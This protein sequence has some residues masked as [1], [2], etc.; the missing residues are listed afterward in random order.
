MFVS[1]AAP[2]APRDCTTSRLAPILDSVLAGYQT[3][4]TGAALRADAEL[5]ERYGVPRE[6]D[7]AAGAA[8][9][10]LFL[11]SAIYGYIRTAECSRLRR[12]YV[13]PADQIFWNDRTAPTTSIASDWTVRQ[14]RRRLDLMGTSLTP[15]LVVRG[16]DAAL[17][18]YSQ[19]FG[20]RV[21]ERYA[22][23]AGH[24][25]QAALTF[26]G[27]T[28]TLTEERREWN[29]DAPVSLRGSPVI[30]NLVVDDADAVGARLVAAG[31]EVVF[32]IAD[33]Y[34]GHREG[35]LRDP[36]GHLWIITTVIRHVPPEE[37]QKHT[38]SR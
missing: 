11:G 16:A 14:S 5:Y 15:R 7:V 33:Q 38:A 13:S 27:V 29:N 34:Y 9:T 21:L 24:V 31:A 22:D 8:L 37:I 3:V 18:F 26:E 35:R 28:L 25:V 6:A 23:D 30:L 2:P 32:P 36:F 20:A 17:R 1:P 10:A 12:T 19:V 4:R